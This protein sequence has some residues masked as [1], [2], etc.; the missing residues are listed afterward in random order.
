MSD[1]TFLLDTN[2]FIEAHQRYYGLDLN[3]GFWAAL[4]HY[5]SEGRV[6]SLDRVR[7][8]LANR[9]DALTAWSKGAPGGLFADSTAGAVV[10]KFT[11]IMTWVDAGQF[12][13]AAT[14]RFAEGADGWLIAYAQVERLVLVTHEVFAAGAKKTVPIPNVCQQF[15]VEHRDT[16]E[17]LRDLEV[18]FDWG[19]S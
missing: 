1:A 5:S 17:M 13:G 16:F 14:A 2:V 4:E 18:R 10:K 15:G 11:E 19:G 3:P 6:R 12:R 7:D 9:G 8:E